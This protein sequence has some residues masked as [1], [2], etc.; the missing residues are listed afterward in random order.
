MRQETDEREMKRSERDQQA[1]SPVR[2]S[3]IVL[4]S[5][6]RGLAARPSAPLHTLI[7]ATRHWLLANTF[8]P[9]WLPP[10]WRMQAVPYAIAGILEL[11]AVLAS[12][13]FF[14]IFPSYSFPGTVELMVVAL[15][16]VSFGGGPSLVATF[17]SLLSLAFLLLPRLP[18]GPLYFPHDSAQLAVFLVCG[19]ALSLV[20][21]GTERGRQRLQREQTEVQAREQIVKQTNARVDE[22][23]SILSH[24]LR[25]PLAGIKAA[26]QLLER[27]I[28][29]LAEQERIARP[30]VARRLDQSLETLTIANR[31]V[32]RQNRLIGDL[33][34]IS[35]IRAGKL[36]YHLASADL[37]TLLHDVIET[38]RLASPDRTITLALP[39]TPIPVHADVDRI[40]QVITNFVT[41][42]LKYA[43]AGPPIEVSLTRTDDAARVAVRDHGPGLSHEQQLQ[44]WDRFHRVPGIVQQSGST[45]LG[46]GLY[47]CK[48]IIEWHSGTVGVES[49]PGRGT[50]FWFTLPLAHA[51]SAP[52]AEESA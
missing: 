30:D 14:V 22:F 12:L 5:A 36:E 33:L 32:E 23:L 8:L 35:R 19:V 31:E 16:A 37:A 27:R 29:R 40:A 38:Q 6:V 24:E 7:R 26:L 20:A 43:P 49:A 39:E 50:M 1:V 48:N 52:L 21:G 51:N 15:I 9:P 42:A 13:L 45:G 47:I 44:V 28:K 41:N 46:L 4:R 34:D 25:S 18:T 17:I 11:V 2:Y 10:R 3:G